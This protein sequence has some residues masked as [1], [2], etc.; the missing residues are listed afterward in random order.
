MN[1]NSL[2][3]S[4]LKFL[5]LSFILIFVWNLVFAMTITP[6]GA[7][8]TVEPFQG[9]SL[10]FGVLSSFVAYLLYQF[11]QA[12]GLEQRIYA[13]KSSI[14]AIKKKNIDLFDKAN[15]LVEKHQVI[16]K[17]SYLDLA[18]A[19]SIRREEKIE[20][21]EHN[22]MTLGSK[23]ET[24]VTSSEEF[25]RFLKDYP[26]LTHNQNIQ[27]LLDQ[28]TENETNLVNAKITYNHC[29]EAYNALIF[30]FPLTL[31]RRMAKFQLQDYYQEDEEI[32]DADLGLDF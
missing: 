8:M 18:K 16:E 12:R 28:I 27:R 30:Q 15:R 4:I 25:G 31:I 6:E 17:E 32:S 7:E 23:Q 14:Q 13:N 22:K 10:L 1:K 21:T 19:N 3:V 5:G 9:A 29:V 26:E 2:F 20:K 24:H 11:N